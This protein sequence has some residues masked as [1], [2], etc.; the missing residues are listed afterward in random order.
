MADIT[1]QISDTHMPRLIAAM[2]AHYGYRDMIDD[3]PN[4]EPKG[5]F[6]KRKITRDWITIVKTQE[7]KEQAEALTITEI[8]IT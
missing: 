5:V 7:R 3:N 1:F 4:P 8:D 2:A 6:I